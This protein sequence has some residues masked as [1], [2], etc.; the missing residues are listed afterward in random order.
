MADAHPQRRSHPQVPAAGTSDTGKLLCCVRGAFI[1]AATLLRRE[2]AEGAAGCSGEAGG[3]G[4][5]SWP[6]ASPG[7]CTPPP[8]GAGPLRDEFSRKRRACQAVQAV[9]AESECPLSVD[10]FSGVKTV[11]LEEGAAT[12]TSNSTCRTDGGSIARA[13]DHTNVSS[14]T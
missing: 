3:L 7:V 5:P 4:A 1:S 6:Q 12:R 10:L 13:Q 11:P 8:Q 9:S 14:L 2:M